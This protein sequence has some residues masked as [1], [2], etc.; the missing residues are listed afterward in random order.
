MA[1]DTEADSIRTDFARPR[2]K[3][4]LSIGVEG[5]GRYLDGCIFDNRDE[6]IIHA[7]G[8]ITLT[9]E[10]RIKGAITM[11]Y[12]RFFGILQLLAFRRQ[13][14]VEYVFTTGVD[15]PM[16]GWLRQGGG[17]SFQ[18]SEVVEDDGEVSARISFDP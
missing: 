16:D 7:E 1:N 9:G 11:I 2:R 4:P 14:T 12:K 13:K 17:S 15:S 8:L 5:G 10:R 18:W 6:A 3:G